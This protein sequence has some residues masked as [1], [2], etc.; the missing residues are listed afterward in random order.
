VNDSAGHWSTVSRASL[1][2]GDALVY[3]SGSAGH[4]VLY[5]KGDGWGTPT[6]VE[7]KGCSYGCVYNARSFAS[8]YKGIRRAGF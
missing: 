1:K 7:C 5:E 6:V 3:N 2:K 4:V 8:T